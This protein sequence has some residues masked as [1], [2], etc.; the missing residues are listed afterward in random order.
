[1]I[2]IRGVITYADGRTESYTGAQRE[3]AAWERYALRHGLPIPGPN[4]EGIMQH[5]TGRYVAYA[6]VHA[7]MPPATWPDFDTWAAGVLE[8]TGDL[9][10]E[11][12]VVGNGASGGAVPP[13][14]REALGE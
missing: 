9:E 3:L 2:E 4:A 13:I 5:T 7:D 10:G 12:G 14:P 6:A 8:V 11:P 1:M